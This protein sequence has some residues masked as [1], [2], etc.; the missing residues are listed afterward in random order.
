MEIKISDL[1]RTD[2]G[3]GT[4]KLMNVT[5]LLPR[6]AFTP[7]FVYHFK[8]RCGGGGGQT[9]PQSKTLTGCRSGTP[10]WDAGSGRQWG[11]DTVQTRGQ[12]AGSGLGTGT[13]T[14]ALHS[15]SL[16]R[17]QGG[18]VGPR[19]LQVLHGVP[20]VDAAL[21]GA[22][23]A[24]VVGGPEQRHAPGEVVVPACHLAGLV[25]DLQGRP[26][27]RRGRGSGPGGTRGAGLESLLHLRL[28]GGHVAARY[29]CG[30]LGHRHRPQ[31]QRWH[32]S[33]S[34]TRKRQNF[35]TLPI[36]QAPR[37]LYIR[38]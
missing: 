38:Q 22:N 10:V 28:R 32:L 25:E 34:P 15:H 33:P 13:G 11:C 4:E 29:H 12:G 35:L 17:E 2:Q 16:V 3:T 36:G 14:E 7:E 21:L 9:L 37:S 1:R 5:E 23:A 18:G 6:N 24:L 19:G 8:R 26:G 20:L 31:E 30:S 27:V